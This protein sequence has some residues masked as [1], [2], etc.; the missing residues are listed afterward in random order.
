MSPPCPV[1]ALG[2]LPHLTLLQPLGPRS[3]LP[4]DGS[5]SPSSRQPEGVRPGIFYRT[6]KH[7]PLLQGEADGFPGQEDYV[8][9]VG[10]AAEAR[11]TQVPTLA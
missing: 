8:V 4:L 6:S 11:P 9:E 1:P 7:L 3:W 10:S 5:G 2:A